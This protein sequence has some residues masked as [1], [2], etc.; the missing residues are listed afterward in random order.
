MKRSKGYIKIN[1]KK[2]HITTS[3]WFTTL[4]I[5]VLGIFLIKLVIDLLEI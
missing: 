2:V 3:N 5:Y 4:L 1:G